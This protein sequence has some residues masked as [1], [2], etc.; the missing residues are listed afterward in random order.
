MDERYTVYCHTNL[1]NGKKY[2]G[3]TKRNPQKRWGRDGN[4]YSRQAFGKAIEK[5]GWDNF[6]HEI[7][8]DGLTEA[9]AKE[10]EKRFVYDLGTMAPNGYNLTSGGEMGKEVSAN[11]REKL[12]ASHIGKPMSESAKEKMSAI[13][14]GKTVSE[15]TRKKISKAR[16]GITESSEWRQHISDGL[17]GKTWS[18]EQRKNYLRNRVYAKGADVKKARKVAKYTKNGT[19][20]EV[21]G[22]IKDAEKSIGN[23]HH[24][25]ECCLG[26]IKTAGGYVWKYVDE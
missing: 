11:T 2:I 25:S 18:E 21:F 20:L 3:I 19:L 14:K 22:C 26:K 23:G 8:A 5:Y 4:R 6:T 10:E 16:K 7:L 1:I 9:Q 15:E 12:R 24:I 17:K 13:H